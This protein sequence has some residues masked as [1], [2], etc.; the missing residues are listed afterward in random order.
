MH[1]KRIRIQAIGRLELLPESVVAAIRAAETATAQ[2]NLMTLTIA[3]GYGGREE[4]SDA[5]RSFLK[6]Q[7]REGAS[8]S[9][10]IERIRPEAIASHLY[11]SNLP[12]G[13]RAQ[14]G[15]R[16]DDQREAPSHVIARPAVEPHPVAVLAEREHAGSP[17]RRGRPVWIQ[18]VHRHGGP[19]GGSSFGVDAEPWALFAMKLQSGTRDIGVRFDRRRMEPERSGSS[20]QRPLG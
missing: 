15:Q 16:I 8:L 6:T 20:S 12:A 19:L 5:V 11:A 17:A 7:A 1:Q 9:D 4:I 13:A 14:A 2:Y 10:A 18:S 3:V